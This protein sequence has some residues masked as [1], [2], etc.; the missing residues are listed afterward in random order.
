MP[1]YEYRC[2]ACGESEEK[3]QALSAPECHDC[4]SCGA[5]EGMRRQV[6]VASFSLGGS[7]WFASGYGK[8]KESKASEPAPAKPT[9]PGGCCGGCACH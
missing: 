1:L 2:Q 8:E 7:G 4:P 6:S 9:E 3:L 5:T